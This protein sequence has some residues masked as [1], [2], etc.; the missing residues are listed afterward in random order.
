[1]TSYVEN[2]HAIHETAGDTKR[3]DLYNL[4][5]ICAVLRATSAAS[6]P[7][8]AGKDLILQ[9]HRKAG[10]PKNADITRG[11]LQT[12]SAQNCCGRSHNCQ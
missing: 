7:K 8:D 2:Q 4:Q 9:L 10:G 1:M 6:R 3:C 12:N 11:T 5:G